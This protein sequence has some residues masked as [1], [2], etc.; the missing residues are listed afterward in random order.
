MDDLPGWF[1]TLDPSRVSLA[2]L[3]TFAVFALFKGLIIPRS[4]HVDRIADKDAV[5]AGLV[6][7]KDDWK[8]AYNAK[9]SEAAEL[10]RQ[11][12][13]LLNA[14]ETTNRLLEALRQRLDQPVQRQIG[15]S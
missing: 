4:V 6:V 14:A 5:I 10:L 15:E 12:S 3:V 8:A 1:G 9:D 11:N 13:D 2:A 7:E